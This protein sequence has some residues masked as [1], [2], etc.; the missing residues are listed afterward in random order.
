[1][2]I[3]FALSM[4]AFAAGCGGAAGPVHGPYT[5]T[6]QRFY[7]T[8]IML[9][10]QRSDYAV[11]LNGDGHVDNQLGNI[12]GAIAGQLAENQH[13]DEILAADR[14]PMVVEL[15]SDDAALREDATVGVRWLG[16]GD[17][18]DQL[19]AVLH[20]GT[21]T[22]NPVTPTAT[23]ASARLPLF[24]AA[25]ASRLSLDHYQLELAPDG[26]GGFVGQL[27]GTI[28][29]ADAVNEIGPQLI[30]MIRNT[31]PPSMIRWFDANR[32]GTITLDELAAYE[33]I[34][35][36]ASPD[37]E[38]GVPANDMKDHLSI[39]FMFTAAPCSD[40]ACTRPVPAASCFDRVHNGDE[41]D[42]DCGGSCGPCASGSACVQASDCDAHACDSGVCRAPS[43]SDAI[44]DGFEIDVDC[45][46]GCAPCVDGAHCS[47]DVDC[48]SN[49]CG[50]DGHGHAVCLAPR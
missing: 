7:V 48:Q 42:V 21:V 32:D 26:A 39:G 24:A 35:S 50:D 12:E 6:A 29:A 40:D 17:A 15:V 31:T 18:A 41:S 19:G 4:F 8:G 34:K 25:D 2:R 45:G 5:G 46:D 37:V 23:Q 14:M 28:V 10:Q 9:P 22:S 11:D 13:I 16:G 38:V 27:N 43:C 3:A 33:F 1:M 30:Q 44:R 36:L 49:H 20:D 47:D